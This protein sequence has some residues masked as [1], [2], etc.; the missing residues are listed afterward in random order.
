MSD[1]QTLLCLPLGL[2]Q[3]LTIHTRKLANT[4]MMWLMVSHHFIFSFNISTAELSDDK[5]TFCFLSICLV[6]RTVCGHVQGANKSS[7]QV[8]DDLC[9]NR[10]LGKVDGKLFEK[11]C[12]IDSG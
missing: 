11:S 1:R 4:F 3:K 8:D 2:G 12:K 10:K 5:Q 6:E 9:L 7:A